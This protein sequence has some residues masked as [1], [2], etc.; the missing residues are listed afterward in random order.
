MQSPLVPWWSPGNAPEVEVVTL[1]EESRRDDSSELAS[2]LARHRE[3]LAEAWAEAICRQL[4]NSRYARLPREELVALSL[5][6]NAA[7]V[8]LLTGG[9]HV[10]WPATGILSPCYLLRSGFDISEVVHA[11]MLSL[12]LSVPAI[13]RI[14]SPD[15]EAAEQAFTEMSAQLRRLLGDFVTELAVQAKQQVEEEQARTAMALRAARAASSSLELTRVLREAGSVLADAAGTRHCW[16]FLMHR[17]GASGGAWAE[18]GE[19]GQAAEYPGEV[20]TSIL[21]RCALEKKS[22][23]VCPDAQAGPFADS[24]WAYRHGLKSVL[25]VP[26]MVEG[27]VLGIAV[28][29]S[30]EQPSQFTPE[31]VDLVQAIANVIAPAIENAR[32]YRKVE[33]IA[34]TVERTRLSRELHDDLAQLLGFLSLKIAA[35]RELI[36]LGKR[37]PAEAALAEM[38]RLVEDTYLDLREAIFC[39]RASVPSGPEFWPALREYL[40]EYQTHYGVQ[41]Q[42]TAKGDAELDFTP[43]VATQ[44]SRIILEA[45]ANVRKHSGADRAWICIERE[46]QHARVTIEDAGRGFDAPRVIESGGTRVGLEIMRERAESV[47]G[48][49]LLNSEPG[50]GTRVVVRVPLIQMEG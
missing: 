20:D 29:L 1:Q 32:L 40:A 37:G 46:G 36:S 5:A 2:L 25:S 28:A 24:D 49:L 18:T 8:D 3:G 22:P 14:C 21:T 6:A 41:V 11:A 30:F 42:L 48:T 23:L 10:A 26:L 43:P 44:L 19:T 27:P 38:A 33:K 16:F 35:T 4:P 39:L 47:G 34:V 15:S 17:G 13:R 45:L 9:P 31:Q 12:E 7:A 50:Y